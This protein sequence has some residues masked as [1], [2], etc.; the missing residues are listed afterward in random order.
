MAKKYIV[1]LTEEERKYLH[2]CFQL[3]KKAPA[4][5]HEPGFCSKRLNLST[6]W[7]T[8]W[9]CT[10]NHVILVIR[11]LALMRLASN[12]FQRPGP[13]LPTPG[14]AARYDYEYRRKGVRNCFC[15][16]NRYVVRATSKS[17]NDAPKQTGHTA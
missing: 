8:C 14:Q 17:Q 15:S 10:T 9:T 12:W 1:T 2:Q 13:L 11:W 7:K 16:S 3:V 6:I 5:S 4:N